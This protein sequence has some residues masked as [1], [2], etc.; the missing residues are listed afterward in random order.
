MCAGLGY[1]GNCRKV[2]HVRSS[3]LS[4]NVVLRLRLQ[5]ERNISLIVGGASRDRYGTG[6]TAPPA[7]PAT[8]GRFPPWRTWRP[9]REDPVIGDSTTTFAWTCAFEP[10]RKPD[11]TRQGLRPTRQKTFFKVQELALGAVIEGLHPTVRSLT[12]MRRRRSDGSK[13]QEG[14]PKPPAI[15]S[16]KGRPEYER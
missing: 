14:V 1:L 15:N 2:D 13:G 3:S 9:L 11:L 5:A 7:E 8:V 16:T 6:W 10:A 4:V 12:L